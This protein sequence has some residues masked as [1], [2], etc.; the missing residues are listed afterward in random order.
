VPA[1]V[2]GRTGDRAIRIAVDGTKVIECSV[3]EAE[4]RWSAALGNWLDS[5][6]A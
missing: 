1:A 3:L 4:A 5:R 6:V 2:I